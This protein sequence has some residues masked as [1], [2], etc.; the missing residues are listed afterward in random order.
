MR[1]QYK[2]SIF[3]LLA[4]AITLVGMLGV[5]FVFAKGQSHNI[6][7]AGLATSAQPATANVVIRHTVDMSTVPATIAS[8]PLSQSPRTMPWLTGVSQSVYAQRKAAAAHNKNASVDAHPYADTS[9]DGPF[10]PTTLVKFKGLAD[11]AKICPYFGGCQPP[12]QA[13]A[14]SPNWV[15]QGGRSFHE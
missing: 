13:L 12:D 3:T 8:S 5:T 14:T 6:A 7:H 1:R 9:V 2:G 11:S 4:L 10:T 15:L